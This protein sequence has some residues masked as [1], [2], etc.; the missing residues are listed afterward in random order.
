MDRQERNHYAVMAAIFILALI[1]RILAR[2]EVLTAGGLLFEGF[3]SYYHIRRTIYTFQ[4]F[5][6]TLWFD[7]YLDYPHGME[8]TWPPLFDLMGSAVSLA[9]GADGPFGVEKACAFLP[10]LIGSLTVVLVYLLMLQLFD[11]RTAILAAFL[12]ALAPYSLQS[13]MLGAYDHHC[14][15]VLLFVAAILFLSRSLREPS[16]GRRDL[17]WAGASGLALALLA[18]TWMGAA[19]YLG[20]IL[21]F[22]VAQMTIDLSRG[23]PSS[24]LALLL[25]VS[26]ALALIAILPFKNAPWMYPSFLALVLMVAALLSLYILAYAMLRRR[27]PWPAFPVAILLMGY[28]L[29]IASPLM[30]GH[31]PALGQVDNI[32]WWGLDYLFGGG[33]SDKISEAGPIFQDI[34]VFSFFG[35]NMVLSLA[36]FVVLLRKRDFSRAHTL[37]LVWIVLALILTV[38]Q[39]R[40]LYLS[41]ISMAL[42][43]SLLYF[44][45]EGLVRGRLKEAWQRPA[46]IILL[47]AIVIPS[48]AEVASI[49]HERPQIAGD[50]QES[51]D[52]LEMNT[53]A[54]EFYDHPDRQAEYSVMSWWDYGNWILYRGKRP[55]VANNFQTGVLDS[56]NF[57]LSEDEE[58][59]AE[60]MDRRR[61]RYVITDMEMIYGKLPAITAWLGEDASSYLSM[62]DWGWYVNVRPLKRLYS[63]TLAGL[64]LLDCSGMGHFRLLYESR[65]TVGSNPPT[66]RVKIFEYVPGAEIMGTTRPDQPVGVLLNLSSNQGRKFQY[67]HM[68]VPEDGRYCIRVPYSTEPAHGTFAIGRYLVFSGGV[69]KDVD[70]TEE[71]VL[72]GRPVEV[73]F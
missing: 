13:S 12:S 2:K 10:P 26:F 48:A 15:E 18:Y 14:L 62:E 60:I 5:P 25:L 24:D 17:L 71:D 68:G 37:F 28:V 22:G 33:L 7:S 70:V 58:G 35:I 20:S 36:G 54:T 51:L 32:L 57:Y 43:I 31:I 61:G 69:S 65:T 1:L 56:A 72:M 21:A 4:N 9:L 38:G 42:L 27:I 3:D 6:H 23:R 16:I 19:V 30:E 59:A 64:Q 47:V 11:S 46:A 53:P 34:S 29:L 41:S 39:K 67:F 40:F 63:T 66:A 8:I 44:H 49:A 73:D 45:V 50:W 55:V 52:W